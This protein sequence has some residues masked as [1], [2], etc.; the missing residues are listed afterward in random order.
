[1]PLE[2]RCTACQNRSASG[3][4]A[5]PSRRSQT[6][7]GVTWATAAHSAVASRRASDT[8]ERSRRPSASASSCAIDGRSGT[9][10]FLLPRELQRGDEVVDL[11]VQHLGE[12][13]D[14]V[15]DAVVGDP[16]LGKIVG[17]DLRRAVAG[18]NH[19]A[20][21]AR[22]RR[23]LLGHHTVEQS[24]PQDFER[25][26]LVLQLGLLV[27]TLDLETGGEVRHADGAIGGIDALPPG[28]P[29]AEDVD[30]Q[31]LVLD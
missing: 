14:G 18:P 31:V 17:A 23:F 13:V 30:A 29:G 12:I 4:A 3:C 7:P 5:S 21:V 27:L 8:P 10:A 19:G 2:R 28:T 25:L 20:P 22:A 16:V 9:E 1:M 26:D 11:T 15:V 6:A 24:R